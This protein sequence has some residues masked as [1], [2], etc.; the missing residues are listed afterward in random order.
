MVLDKL[1]GIAYGKVDGPSRVLNSVAQQLHICVLTKLQSEI[2]VFY[3]EVLC[4]ENNELLAVPSK[5]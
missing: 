3:Y 4:C 1:W 2:F 5:F